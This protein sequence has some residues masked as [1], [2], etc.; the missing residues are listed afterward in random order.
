MDG[1]FIPIVFMSINEHLKSVYRQR[2]TYTGKFIA[3]MFG[4]FHTE[5]TQC[6]RTGQVDARQQPTDNNTK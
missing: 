2:L 4:W 5:I 6:N 3:K 1:H